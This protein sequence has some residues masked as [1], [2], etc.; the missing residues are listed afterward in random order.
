MRIFAMVLCLVL[1]LAACGQPAGSVGASNRRVQ[2]ADN[3]FDIP[4]AASVNPD[5]RVG[6]I[7]LGGPRAT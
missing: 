5:P 7:F 1:V 6:A 3:P 2:L 4:V